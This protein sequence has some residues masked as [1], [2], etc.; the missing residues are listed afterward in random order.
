MAILHQAQ[1]RPTKLELL[2]NWLP[3]QPWFVGDADAEFVNVA[4]YRFDDPQGD[5]GIETILVRA[6]TGPTLQAPLTYRGAPLDGAESALICTMEHSVLGTR[7]VYNGVADPVYLHVAA[8]AAL[9]GGHQVELMVE[10]ADGSRVEREPTAL[11]AGTG[12]GNATVAVPSARAI[13]VNDSEGDT[14]SV[15][16][17]LTVRV[18]RVLDGSAEPSVEPRIDSTG[19]TGAL[20][21][22]WK[23]SGGDHELV[24]VTLGT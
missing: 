2:A 7:W 18:R 13:T 9:N 5:V 20:T 11:V 22:S 10:M 14:E 12:T 4:A 16:G 23:D 6:G 24:L 8:T 21:G 3:T 1:I 19:I 17:P 15:A